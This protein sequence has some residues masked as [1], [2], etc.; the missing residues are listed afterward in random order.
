MQTIFNLLWNGVITI[1]AATLPKSQGFSSGMYNSL[2]QLITYT[3]VWG[4]VIPWGVVFNILAYTFYFE[5]TVLTFKFVR[6]VI[7]YVPR[8]MEATA[9]ASSAVGQ[10]ASALFAFITTLF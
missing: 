1:F 10:G 5:S 6:M 7:G 2:A 3:N 9:A 8:L 4:V